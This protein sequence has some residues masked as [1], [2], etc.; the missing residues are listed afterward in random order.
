MY[1]SFYDLDYYSHFDGH[2][3]DS[4]YQYYRG[5]VE[6]SIEEFDTLKGIIK[7]YQKENGDKNGSAIKEW[8]DCEVRLTNGDEYVVEKSDFLDYFTIVDES[9]LKWE[10]EGSMGQ[11]DYENGSEII[12]RKSAKSEIK[13]TK[14]TEEESRE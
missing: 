13:K 5:A 2:T 6:I 4:I 10:Y 14:C 8:Y 11:G 12:V 3:S 7:K 9:T 1:G